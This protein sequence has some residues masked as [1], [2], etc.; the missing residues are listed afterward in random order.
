MDGGS[1]V[2]RADTKSETPSQTKATD[3]PKAAVAETTAAPPPPPETKKDAP[4]P[5]VTKKETP[6]PPP[7]PPPPPKDEPKGDPT[8]PVVFY[9]KD[10]KTI[11]QARC[12]RC[13][14][15]G[16]KAKGGLDTRTF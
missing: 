7:P 15:E 6:P 11:M 8:A 12:D 4:P 3:Q 16:G 1:Q 14:G 9:D 5:P 2:P 13:H 10:I